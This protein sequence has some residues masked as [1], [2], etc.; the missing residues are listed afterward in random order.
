MKHFFQIFVGC[1]AVAVMVL[2]A[3]ASETTRVF[4]D[5]IQY[6]QKGKYD[7]AAEEFEK[8]EKSGVRNGKLYYNIGNAYFK[9]NDIGRAILWYERAKKM[10][11][12]DPDLEFNLN[13][14]RSFLKDEAPEDV[15]PLYRILFFWYYLLSRRVVLIC[16]L[17]AN[18]VFWLLLAAYRIKPR[19][20]FRAAAYPVGFVAL[21]FA[22]TACYGYYEDRS[23]MA[24]VLTEKLSVRS[25]LSEEST[26]LFV[27]HAGTRVRVEEERRGYFRIHFSKGKIGWVVTESV[28]II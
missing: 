22:L 16:G 9:K 11:P 4:F 14:A 24:V 12:G 27:L 23:R 18:L 6:Y 25:G 17:T 10:I 7:A 3:G 26:E 20:G 2:H 13:Y 28:G 1:L 15:S 21:L 5:A 19:F 8:I